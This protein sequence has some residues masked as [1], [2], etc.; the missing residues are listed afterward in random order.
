ML[1][2]GQHD[3]AIDVLSKADAELDASPAL[4]K[5]SLGYAYGRTG[6]DELS[7][8][9]YE[10]IADH[11]ASGWEPQHAWFSVQYRLAELYAKR[12]ER[13]KAADRLDRMLALW[14]NGDA[15][16][17]LLTAARKLRGSL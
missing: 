4:T 16:L 13:D 12:G 11:E 10:G 7:I 3:Q 14:A 1:A 15:S 5:D 2:R 8:R 17:P 6:R 9:A